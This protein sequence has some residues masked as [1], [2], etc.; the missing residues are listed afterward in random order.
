[1]FSSI[2]NKIFVGILIIIFFTLVTFCIP[3]EE[4]GV[5][6]FDVYERLLFCCNIQIGT[7]GFID[8][9]IFPKTN[10]AKIILFIQRVTSYIFRIIL[11][12]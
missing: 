7:F 6:E 3:N 1:M 12:I 8:T 9:N 10:R 5:E 2:K 11:I 4:W